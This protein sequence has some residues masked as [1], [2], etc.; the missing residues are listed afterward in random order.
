MAG[1]ARQTVKVI[2][3]PQGERAANQF[4]VSPL[5]QIN[6]YPP[7]VS[8]GQGCF[9]PLLA[10]RA[11]CL[12]PLMVK[13]T[14]TFLVISSSAQSSFLFAPFFSN[15]ISSFL[16]CS[17]ATVPLFAAGEVKTPGSGNISPGIVLPP[18]E[19]WAPKMTWQGLVVRNSQAWGLHTPGGPLEHSPVS[20]IERAELC[21]II[22]TRGT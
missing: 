6:D 22:L 2:D 16:H 8:R 11:P 12:C 14:P 7:D 13:Y 21:G 3:P 9:C 19:A 18:S 1:R 5:F 15:L 10:I 4:C 17:T 20:R